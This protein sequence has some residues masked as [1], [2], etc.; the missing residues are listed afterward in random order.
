MKTSANI[1]RAFFNQDKDN[2]QTKWN[3][4]RRYSI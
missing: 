2:N 4:K 3:S 1:R